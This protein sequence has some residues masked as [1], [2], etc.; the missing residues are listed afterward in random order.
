M[1]KWHANFYYRSPP[2]A[3]VWLSCEQSGERVGKHTSSDST[4]TY[5]MPVNRVVSKKPRRREH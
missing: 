4:A 2:D 3:G 1:G 5:A